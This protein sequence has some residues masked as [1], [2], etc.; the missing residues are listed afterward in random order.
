MS[1]F[2]GNGERSCGFAQLYGCS[3]AS[4]E[5]QVGT[6]ITITKLSKFLFAQQTTDRIM[7][8]A[9]AT[10]K[11]RFQILGK[12][13]THIP[14]QVRRNQDRT[15]IFC[16]ASSNGNADTRQ[17]L[18]T[19]SLNGANYVTHLLLITLLCGEAR[20][21]QKIWFCKRAKKS[22][23]S[24]GTA[25]IDTNIYPCCIISCHIFS[26]ND[27]IKALPLKLAVRTKN[28]MCNNRA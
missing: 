10:A 20:S 24:T 7:R 5:R 21:K 23:T 4:R 26:A 14:G 15:A 18:N 25:S 17:F 12:R 11:L 27:P 1:D 2:D 3:G 13:L 22:Y 8:Q 6:A 28:T 9:D 16:H 19:A